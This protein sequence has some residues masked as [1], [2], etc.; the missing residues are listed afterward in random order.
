M[1]RKNNKKGT[2]RGRFF[3]CNFSKVQEKN[4]PLFAIFQKC[5]KRGCLKSNIK[6]D[7]KLSLDFKFSSLNV[8]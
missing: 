6:K 2:K 5:K 1:I 8:I 3:S 4:R 7:E